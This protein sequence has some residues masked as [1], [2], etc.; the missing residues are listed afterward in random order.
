MAYIKW[1]LPNKWKGKIRV[2][3]FE[4][5]ASSEYT[6]LPEVV[7]YDE[8]T[9]SKPGFDLIAGSNTLK[10]LGIILDFRTKEIIIDEISLPMRDMNNLR[11][12]AAANKA[13]TMNNSIYQSTPKSCRAH[14]RLQNASSKSLMPNMKMQISGQLPKRIASITS[15]QQKRTSC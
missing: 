4:Y 14:S 15:G 7:E 3:F 2:K 8:A 13:W 5:L 10:E 12:R 6:L 9:M 11:T 1:E